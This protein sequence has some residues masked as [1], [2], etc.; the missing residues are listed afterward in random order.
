MDL[1][2]FNK[3]SFNSSAFQDPRQQL[4]AQMQQQGSQSNKESLLQRLLPSIGGIG[5]GAAGAAIG[6]A[7]LPGVGTLAGA[8]IGGALGGGGGKAVEN[9]TSGQSV[10]HDVLR[11]SLM[12]GVLSAGPLRIGK[13]AL[14]TVK[15]VRAGKDLLEATNAGAKSANNLSLLKS[16]G[17]KLDNKGTGL[18]AK[19]FRLTPTQQFN[20]KNLHGENATDVLRRYGIK[21]PGDI[22]ER[23]Q[24]LQDSFNGVVNKIPAINSQDL[25]QGLKSVYDPLLKSP[26]IFEQNLGQQVKAQADELLKRA[27]GGE[28]SAADVNN[29][30]KLFDNAVNYTQRGAPEFNVLKKT[31]DA[32]RKTLQGAADRAGVTSNGK[33]FKEIGIELNKLHGLNDIVGKQTF[34]GT[35]SL[36]LNLPSLLGG[37][38]GGAAGGVPGM[39]IGG[40]VTQAVNSAT[41]RR[42]AANGLIK[43]GDRLIARGTKNSVTPF[44]VKNTAKR[45][46]SGDI[47]RSLNQSS[48]GNN[49]A[50]AAMTNNATTIP[51]TVDMTGQYSNKSGSSSPQDLLSGSQGVSPQELLSGSQDQTTEGSTQYYLDGAQRAAAAGDF[52]SAA[53]L[54]DMAKTVAALT[55]PTTANNHT[56]STAQQFAIAQSGVGAL[57]Q[58][59][60]MIQNDPSL[61]NETAIPGQNTPFIGGLVS[62]LAGTGQY[63]ALANQV[64]DAI[65]RARTGAAMTKTEEAFYRNL[66]PQAG[67][68]PTTIN[69]KLQ[70]LYQAF[71]PFLGGGSDSPTDLL[72]QLNAATATN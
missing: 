60:Q 49:M 52:D 63:N 57:G 28:L 48:S 8:L 61:V 20:F 16:V 1:Q 32:L 47:L 11:E 13:F 51:N 35:G 9:A 69:T 54:M 58:L 41:G 22:T 29:M 68:N 59:S 38:A 4:I 65:A 50:T 53:Q 43:A 36:P 15:G 64:L 10:G 27:A 14:D 37:A 19:E 24:P 17:N 34:N 40:A 39:L 72:S 44:G 18:I 62:R 26:A 2:G 66:L 6:T 45:I 71:Q 3:A 5:G 7:I 23:I 25:S 67:D 30:R 55:Q 12:N 56:K 21:R 46:V 70:Q 42:I 31:A 33:T